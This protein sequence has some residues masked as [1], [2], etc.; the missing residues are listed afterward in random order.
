MCYYACVVVPKSVYEEFRGVFDQLNNSYPTGTK[1]PADVFTKSF[2]YT[3][4]R[5]GVVAFS[6]SEADPLTSN[7]KNNCPEYFDQYLYDYFSSRIFHSEFSKKDCLF[8][9]FALNETEYEAIFASF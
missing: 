2:V 7:T 1:K 8:Y 5:S 4:K 3:L 6:T 9:I